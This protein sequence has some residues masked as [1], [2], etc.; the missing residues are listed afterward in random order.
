M[1]PSGLN[2]KIVK[3]FLQGIEGCFEELGK[4]V[5]SGKHK[6]FS[7][8]IK[9]EVKQISKALSQLHIN[10]RGRLVLRRERS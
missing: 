6:D 1:P 8:A 3:G 7:T 9:H 2:A 10:K 5:E 4:E